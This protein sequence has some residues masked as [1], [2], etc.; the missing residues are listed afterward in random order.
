LYKYL[1]NNGHRFDSL[2]LDISISLLGEDYI[3]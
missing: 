1:M 3:Y 2:N